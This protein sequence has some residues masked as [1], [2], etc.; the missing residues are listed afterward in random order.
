[1]NSTSTPDKM[2]RYPIYWNRNQVDAMR[3]FLADRYN[4][5]RN[6]EDDMLITDVLGTGYLSRIRAINP[7]VHSAA[8]DF[9]RHPDI[10]GGYMYVFCLQV[11][12]RWSTL[13]RIEKELYKGFKVHCE[14]E[15]F[16]GYQAN[17][18]RII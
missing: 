8:I 12:N 13:N 7:K 18:F 15:Y 5:I 11:F 2:R 14:G 4:V 16:G 9:C 10:N 6:P 17:Y 3:I 1:M